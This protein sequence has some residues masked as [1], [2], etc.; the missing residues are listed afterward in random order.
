[1]SNI[2]LQRLGNCF[3]ATVLEAVGDTFTVRP[4][5]EWDRINLAG[6]IPKNDKCTVGDLAKITLE[7][8]KW[9]AD[10]ELAAECIPVTSIV[11]QF[12]SEVSPGTTVVFD[13]MTLPTTATH[14]EIIWTIDDEIVTE[15]TSPAEI[16]E[17]L[18]VTVTATI[19]NGRCGGIDFNRNFNVS[20][21]EE[22]I[23][24]GEMFTCP[25]IN[26]SGVQID[27]WMDGTELKAFV[28]GSIRFFGGS[29]NATAFVFGGTPFTIGNSM[30]F[31]DV[32]LSASNAT[33]DI[34][35]N[36]DG[37]VNGGSIFIFVIDRDKIPSFSTGLDVFS[38]IEPGCEISITV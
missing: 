8:N 5:P 24:P 28:S 14:Q 34:P 19:E 12:A 9:Y 1:M 38:L 10:C 7:N 31:A 23:V 26:V 27:S 21:R 11:R 36:T 20:V 3:L 15:Y 30:Y 2:F 13:G 4:W 6:V 29:G 18:T 17:S 33:V 37:I 16:E 22:E 32:N 25:V 35:A